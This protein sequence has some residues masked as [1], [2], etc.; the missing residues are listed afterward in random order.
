MFFYE[1]TKYIPT[2]D[3]I[4]ISPNVASTEGYVPGIPTSWSEVEVGK[5]GSTIPEQCNQYSNP[6][7]NL[8]IPVKTYRQ[9]L[10]LTTTT[11]GD[12]CDFFR[13]IYQPLI[14]VCSFP[15]V[16]YA[17]L[18]YGAMLAWGGILVTTES[19]FFSTDPYNFDTIGIG[20]LNMPLL[21]G[22]VLATIYSGPLSDWLI[23]WLATRNKGIYEPEMRLYLAIFPALLQSGGLFLYGYSVSAVS[24]SPAEF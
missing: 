10:V 3:D 17:A 9:R 11:S 5:A 1:E 16:T 2:T 14:V 15:A 22:Q 7:L 18:Q 8:N 12:I 19:D 24:Y 13:H 4:G 21:I 20:L 23:Q 6:V